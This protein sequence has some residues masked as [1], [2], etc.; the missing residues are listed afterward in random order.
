MDFLV[1]Q[2]LDLRAYVDGPIDD[3]DAESLSSVSAEVAADFWSGVDVD[4]EVVR[5][6]APARIDDFASSRFRAQRGDVIL[7]IS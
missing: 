7:S 6:D 1:R 4:H 2:I 3:D 5:C